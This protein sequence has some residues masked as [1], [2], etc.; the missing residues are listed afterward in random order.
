MKNVYARNAD[1]SIKQKQPC[2]DCDWP[3]WHVCPKRMSPEVPVEILNKHVGRHNARILGIMAPRSQAH[4]D[5]I[6]IA[7]SE[8]WARIR[9]QQ[10]PVFDSIVAQ[11]EAGKGVVELAK[12]Y[13]FSKDKIL[14]ILK[15]TEEREARTIRR[16]PGYNI[17]H[18]AVE[19]HRLQESINN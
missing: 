12:A 16:K 7:Q 17:R 1:G 4:K 18:G 3:N 15:D 10:R 2:A 5:A 13:T 14:R 11:Y 8:R 19:L 9:E 6:A